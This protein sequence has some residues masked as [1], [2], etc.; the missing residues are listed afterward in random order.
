VR[1]RIAG[2]SLLMGGLWCGFMVTLREP[3]RYIICVMHQAK[4]EKSENEKRVPA[5]MS[6]SSFSKKGSKRLHFY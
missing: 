5:L 4:G 2:Q 6:P 1:N 3:T